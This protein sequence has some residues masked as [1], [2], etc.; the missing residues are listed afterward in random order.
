MN[1]ELFYFI[2]YYSYEYWEDQISRSARPPFWEG[3]EPWVQD[4]E[5]ELEHAEPR[6][7]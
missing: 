5:L 4:A 2:L 6:P 1:I 7:V 3:G